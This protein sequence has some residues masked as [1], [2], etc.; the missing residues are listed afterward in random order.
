[1]EGK[2]CVLSDTEDFQTLLSNNATNLRFERYD[3]LYI[4]IAL[5]YIDVARQCR[6]VVVVII[7]RIV[8]FRGG[9]REYEQSCTYTIHPCAIPLRSHANVSHQ[10]QDAV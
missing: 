3:A 5:C 6:V 2:F 4:Q 7:I 9:R 1:M 8:A 10:V